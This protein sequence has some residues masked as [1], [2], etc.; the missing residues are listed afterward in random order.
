MIHASFYMCYITIFSVVSSNYMQIY[1]FNNNLLQHSCN[2]TITNEVLL[3]ILLRIW[4]L[5]CLFFYWV[6]LM[7]I[8]GILVLRFQTSRTYYSSGY[9]IVISPVFT[10]C[11][12]YVLYKWVSVNI[13]NNTSP[14]LPIMWLNC[15]F[16]V[17]LL[18]TLMSHF[19]EVR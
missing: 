12:K 5:L 13:K 2:V 18:S 16:H 19:R 8:C 15:V 11:I 17:G 10:E 4:I 6:N 7:T 3:I 9:W 1:C 14:N